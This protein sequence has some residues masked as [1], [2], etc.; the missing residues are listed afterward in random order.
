MV[1]FG[2]Y[3]VRPS[4]RE[5]FRQGVRVKLPPQ[6][7]EVLRVLLEHRGE[8]VTR[9]DF[10]RVLW[11]ADTF[12]DFDQG[13][14]NAVKR[15]RE[16][17]NDSA[18]SPRYIE[19]LPRLGYRF[20][21][22]IDST[23]PEPMDLR[24]N[25]VQPP[26]PAKTV[27]P[28]PGDKPEMELPARRKAG[29]RILLA[30]AVGIGLLVLAWLFRPTY[31]EPRITGEI[32]L[33]ADGTPKW[34]ALATDGQRVYFTEILNGRETIAT[35]PVSGGQAVPLKTP[36]A[37]AGMYGI[38]P[39]RNDLLIAETSNMFDDAP[40]WRLPIF[41]GT[42]RRLGNI[43]GHDASWSPDGTKVAYVVGDGVHL[44]NADGSDPHTLVAPRSMPEEWAWRPTWSPDS[45]RL[46]FDYYDMGTHRSQI[47]EVNAD[48]TNPHALFA[49]SADCPMQA[50][51]SWTA[52]GKY[53]VFTSW[54]ELESSI[55][56]P[57]ANLWAVREKGDFLHR[58]SQLPYDLTTGPIRYF[59][60]T[61]SSD[62]KTIFALSSL[63]HGE[64]MRYDMRTKS[65]S[66]YASGLSA[67]GVN[68]S[69]DG[70]WVAYVKYPGG[71]LWRSRVDGS[72]PLQLSS[73][74]LFSSTPMWSPD[75]KQIAFV[76]MKPGEASHIYIVSAD[77]GSPQQIS[78]I[79]S[80]V[81]PD[82]SP[83]GNSLT[84]VDGRDP[85]GT[86]RVLN[87]QTRSVASVA[88]SRGLRSP[89]T[90]PDGRWLAALSNDFQRLLVFDQKN[91][92]WRELA[93]SSSIGWHHWS[94]DSKYVYFAPIEPHLEVFRIKVQGGTPDPVVS[95][96]NIRT[97]GVGPGWFSL[98][99]EGDVLLL[100]DTGGGTEIYA[101]SLNA[102]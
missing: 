54:R 93:R 86:I 22:E 35:V 49:G 12:V 21:G 48:G 26:P 62:G 44:A 52:D 82:W 64:L 46:R 37:Q 59:V 19:T 28:D 51:G 68:F 71:E 14:N 8:L 57:A 70:A 101:L 2:P 1:R 98:T 11:T 47:W 31:R 10:H 43:V 53:Y 72:E 41:G 92:G 36:F 50:A 69:R 88:G 78:E 56:W 67:E 84:F 3:E 40:L 55:P 18:E 58:N 45:R 20:I 30:A 91:S 9:Q 23:Q 102:P 29:A 63:K 75:G 16:V 4:T 99:P 6:A 89:A 13:L 79:G 81:D 94:A 60:S 96:K 77:G 95:L 7:F 87:L 100:H 65:L 85:N 83:D 66:L 38:S 32:Q 73:R 61:A 24:S 90:S 33:T 76:G 39:D 15:I 5:L 17:L 25:G 34:G 80:A 74:P 97:A 27:E 42:P